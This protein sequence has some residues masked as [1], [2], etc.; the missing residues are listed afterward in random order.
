ML[1]ER[2]SGWSYQT[3]VGMAQDV[4]FTYHLSSASRPFDGFFP[5]FCVDVLLFIISGY[6]AFFR[7]SYRRRNISTQ[8][9]YL[10]LFVFSS[11]NCRL[12]AGSRL[13]FRCLS[14][15]WRLSVHSTNNHLSSSNRDTIGK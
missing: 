11:S 1:Q 4:F 2:E 12:R 15:S 5:L 7:S 9:F 14:M 3:R 8:A 6:L 10:L 13:V